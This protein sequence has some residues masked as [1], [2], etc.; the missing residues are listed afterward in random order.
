MTRRLA[1][2]LV[3]AVVVSA[4]GSSQSGGAGQ[5]WQTDAPVQVMDGRTWVVGAHLVTVAPDAA[6]VGKVAVG[7][8]VHV[9]GR[10]TEKGELLV[11]SVQVVGASAAPT[12]APAPARTNPTPTVRPPLPPPKKKNGDHGD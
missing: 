7:S 10:R 3:M 6:V 12:V 2:V 4:C 5:E 11:D 1:V 9:S 8:T